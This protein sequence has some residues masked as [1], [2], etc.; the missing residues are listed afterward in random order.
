MSTP[1]QPLPPGGPSR[2]SVA[3]A[4]IGVTVVT[5]RTARAIVGLFLIA[6][7]VVPLSEWRT[8]RERGVEVVAVHAVKVRAVPDGGGLWSRVVAKN[9]IVLEGLSEFEGAIEDGSHMGRTLRPGAQAVMSQW[10]GVG[11]E[12]VYVGREGWLFYRPD[13]EYATG[14]PFLDAAQIARR[15]RAAPEWSALPA[16]DPRPAI[17]QFHQDLAAR[18]IVLIVMPTPVKPVVHPE[19]LRAGFA[20]G[21]GV[22]HNASYRTLIDDLRRAGVRVFDPSESIASWRNSGPQYLATDTHWTPEAM[23]AVASLAATVISTAVTLPPVP[24]PGYL[25]ERA[26][27]QNVG[28]T[29]KMLDLPDTAG[30]LQPQTVW[31]RRVLLRDGQLWRSAG[32]ADIL[33]LGDS[34]SNIYSLESMG[35]GT[36]AGLAEHL[37]LALG[38]PLDRL[39]QNDQGAFATRA[40]LHSTPARLEGKRVVIYQFAVRELAA[41]DWKVLPAR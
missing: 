41:G 39:V 25:V 19:M 2:E 6:V 9:R 8:I 28:D 12:R 5:P 10:L 24:D 13:I 22:V 36:S 3:Q 4:E 18:G 32:D 29:A 7:G 15:I 26:E 16:P 31:L 20:S 17:V 30:L 23:E 21:S 11:N 1:Q 40:M 27:V 14:Q 34:F 33:L 35:W 38:R 37:S